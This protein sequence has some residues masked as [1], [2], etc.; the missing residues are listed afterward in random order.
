M[1]IQDLFIYAGLPIYPRFAKN[2]WLTLGNKRGM[3]DMNISFHK[4]ETPFNQLVS[5]FKDDHN[6]IGYL[7]VIN[8]L[9]NKGIKVV[10]PT[11]EQCLAFEN[12][13]INIPFKDYKQPYETMC[14]EFPDKYKNLLMSRFGRKTPLAVVCHRP[15]DKEYMIGGVAF[16]VKNYSITFFITNNESQL[17]EM[18]KW[19]ETDDPDFKPLKHAER[20]ALNIMLFMTHYGHTKLGYTNIKQHRYYER[21]EPLKAKQDFYYVGI[22]QEIPIFR[23]QTYKQSDKEPG[24]HASPISHWRKGYFRLQHYGVKNSL[25]KVI[26]IAATFVCPDNYKGELSETKVTYK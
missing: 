10:K 2:E 1:N 22:N 8:E 17:E 21:K 11:F 26:F 6:A 24:T 5:S 3:I 23:K 18:I 9:Y 15:N 16:G 19:N 25:T 20:V 13:E 14:V 7:Y 4:I 12:I